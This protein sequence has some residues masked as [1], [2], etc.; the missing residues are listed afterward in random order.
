MII[1]PG[2]L[3][4]FEVGLTAMPIELYQCWRIVSERERERLRK[5]I[6]IFGSSTIEKEQHSIRCASF[7]FDRHSELV[8]VVVYVQ[9]KCDA[10]LRGD[11]KGRGGLLLLLQ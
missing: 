3:R 5:Q 6:Q 2:L 9:C 7:S 11:V 1:K 10:T 8:L 4:A